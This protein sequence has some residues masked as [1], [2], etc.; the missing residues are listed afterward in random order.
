MEGPHNTIVHAESARKNSAPVRNKSERT[1]P[2][3]IDA[4]RANALRS[5]EKMKRRKRKISNS[6][7][8]QKPGTHSD[9]VELLRLEAMKS[10]GQRGYQLGSATGRDEKETCNSTTSDCQTHNLRDLALQSKTGIIERSK[11]KALSGH[12]PLPK[13]VPISFGTQDTISYPFALSKLFMFV[14][15]ADAKLFSTTQPKNQHPESVC[16]GLPLSLNRLLSQISCKKPWH[17]QG[18]EPWTPERRLL[19]KFDDD[20]SCQT[21]T[22][23]NEK[24]VRVENCESQSTIAQ[25]HSSILKEI[26]RMK[27]QIAL[28][29]R[30]RKREAELR[31]AESIVAA[32]KEKYLNIK[33]HRPHIETENPSL[34]VSRSKFDL[35]ARIKT[36]SKKLNDV[37]R[38]TLIKEPVKPKW[39]LATIVS[40]L[41]RHP[42]YS[43]KL[44]VLGKCILSYIQQCATKEWKKTNFANMPTK[45]L[46]EKANDKFVVLLYK[47]FLLHVNEMQAKFRKHVTA[48]ESAMMNTQNLLK[49]ER[50]MMHSVKVNL[51]KLGVKNV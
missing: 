50:I 37:S 29:E 4:L 45:Q 27:K 44:S 10:I 43:K 13:L 26:L 19:V 6:S 48:L 21:R 11:P 20:N 42:D 32:A 47:E 8:I 16:D 38:G 28:G 15:N 30:K 22:A 35:Q 5:L 7:R 46:Y 39:K 23:R 17:G 12:S 40:C 18:N 34:T 24:K 31:K 3:N 51:Q 33:K 49:Q 9:D 36:L 25:N 41:S 1:P 2:N 14:K